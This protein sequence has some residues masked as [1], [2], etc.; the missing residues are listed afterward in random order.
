MGGFYGYLYN[1]CAAMGSQLGDGTAN[2]NSGNACI[3]GATNASTFDAEISICPA[4]WRLPTG[5]GGELW[6]MSYDPSVNATSDAQGIINFRNNFLAVFSGYYSDYFGGQG[7]GGTYW[8][9][10]VPDSGDASYNL[11]FWGSGTTQGT[12]ASSRRSA[13]AVRCVR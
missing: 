3:E 10:T 11:D 12:S 1:W 2:A 9:G 8:S 5:G 7:G 6:D 13:Y 4:G